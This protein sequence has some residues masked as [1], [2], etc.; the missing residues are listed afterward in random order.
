[1]FEL[2]PEDQQPKPTLLNPNADD[3]KKAKVLGVGCKVQ[4]IKEYDVITL[5]NNDIMIVED[6]TGYCTE[7]N[8]I[9]INDKPQPNKTNILPENSLSISK[10]SKATVLTS[11]DPQLKKGDKVGYKKASGLVLPDQSEIISDTQIFFKV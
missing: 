8:P 1:M 4:Y 11:T 5:Y 7:T 2:L 3:L 9:F 6:N 10:F